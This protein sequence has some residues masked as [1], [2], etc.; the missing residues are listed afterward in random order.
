[1]TTKRQRQQQKQRLRQR[2][3]QQQNYLVEE[4]GG[5]KVFDVLAAADELCGFSFDED[6]GGAGAGVVVR[7][8]GHAVGP[9]CQ[10]S[11][12]RLG[13]EQAAEKKCLPEKNVPSQR[14]P[15]SLAIRFRLQLDLT[16][17]KLTGTQLANNKQ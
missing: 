17:E 2:Q 1:M 14:H 12:G 13:E 16:I 8:L 11:S 4:F 5:E 10:L 7:G 6:L 15:T 3:K 9:V